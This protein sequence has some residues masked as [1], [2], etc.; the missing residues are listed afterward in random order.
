MAFAGGQG[1][2]ASV[3]YAAVRDS[4]AAAATALPRFCTPVMT[5]GPKPVIVLPGLMLT[6]AL[7]VPPVT[8]VTAVP[9]MMPF[10]A[11][12]PSDT[13]GG[14]TGDVTITVA[15]ALMLPLV[16]LTVLL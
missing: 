2:P 14:T 3:L 4:C 9:A 11:A 6:S 12:L 7:M 1:S 15:F 16:A 13:T 5:Q 10:G 8:Q